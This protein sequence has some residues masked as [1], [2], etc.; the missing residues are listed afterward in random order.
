M[1]DPLDDELS[2]LD[3]TVQDP[4]ISDNH[5][6]E[7][8]ERLTE[9]APA[10]LSTVEEFH[11]NLELCSNNLRRADA[12]ATEALKLQRRGKVC[13]LEAEELD[14]LSPG[15]LSP[16]N[17]IGLY[18]EQTSTTNVKDTVTTL[19][20]ASALLA[21]QSIAQTKELLTELAKLLIR[22]G[23][24]ALL[25]LDE[26]QLALSKAL[27][28]FVQAHG[29]QSID[30]MRLGGG[31]GSTKQAMAL[32]LSPIDAELNPDDPYAIYTTTLYKSMGSFAVSGCF[33]EIM[34]GGPHLFAQDKAYLLHGLAAGQGLCYA[35]T[36]RGLNPP[37][38][39]L[40]CGIMA[41]AGQPEYQAYFRLLA[42]AMLGL[43]KHMADLTTQLT[44]EPSEDSLSVA[45]IAAIAYEAAGVARA[46]KTRLDQVHVFVTATADLYAAL[47]GVSRTPNQ[48]LELSTE[49]WKRLGLKAKS[50]M[51]MF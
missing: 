46:L 43:A 39:A 30:Q 19:Q 15:L 11:A 21:S 2:V 16:Q 42:G 22:Q 24:S 5:N 31:I 34:A 8:L 49:T 17:P 33:S 29:D 50:R 37:S 7:N 3:V 36:N 35:R 9:H 14:A 10:D 41:R 1:T 12:I 18:T 20:S 47:C 25:M 38:E 32:P 28:A 51:L 13:A 45:Q 6:A 26:D 48:P 44:A 4:T 40:L 27:T 23:E